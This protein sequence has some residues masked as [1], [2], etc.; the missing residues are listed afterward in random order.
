MQKSLTMTGSSAD[1]KRLMACGNSLGSD[2]GLACC[3]EGHVSI[4]EA[5]ADWMPDFKCMLGPTSDVHVFG[6]GA[7]CK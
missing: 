5:M 3:P 2:F 1:Q 6:A 4:D 7:G